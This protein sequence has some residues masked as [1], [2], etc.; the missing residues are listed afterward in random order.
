MTRPPAS[1]ATFGALSAAQQAFVDRLCDA[2]E[3]HCRK[4]SQSAIERFVKQSPAEIRPQVI[5]ELVAI[6]LEYRRR[7]GDIPTW[8]DYE[9]RFP[10]LDPDWFDRELS[11]RTSSSGPATEMT[12]AMQASVANSLSDT[13]GDGKPGSDEA[14]EAA[15]AQVR[16]QRDLGE[17]E[18]LRELGRGGMGRVYLARHRRMDRIVAIKTLAPQLVRQP[19]AVKRFR[20]EVKA[21]ARLVHPNIVTAYDAGEKDGV[22]FLV[23]EYVDGLDLRSLVERDGPLPLKT[24]VD[25]VIQ[26]A[27]GLARAHSRGVVHR[28]VKPSNLLLDTE[29]IVKV[30]DLGL[31]RVEMERSH[32]EGELTAPNML[33]GTV[34]F[35]APEQ[36]HGPMH[37]DARADIYSLGCTLY[38]LLTSTTPYPE[39]NMVDTILAH[40][41]KPVVSLRDAR[42]D[43]PAELDA[44]FRRMLAKDPAERPQ[45]MEDLIVE[46]RDVL[47]PS[48]R[49]VAQQ[50]HES[51]YRQR[52]SSFEPRS[53]PAPRKPRS[54]SAA[55]APWLTVRATIGVVATLAVAAIAVLRLWPTPGGQTIPDHADGLA[56]LG[57]FG[58]PEDSPGEGFA[59]DPA[60]SPAAPKGVWSPAS[61]ETSA[62]VVEGDGPALLVTPFNDEQAHQAQ[63]D[64]AAHRGFDDPWLYNSINMHLMLI[65]PGTFTAG[66]SL[67]ELREWESLA[68]AGARIE[69]PGSSVDPHRETIGYPF[70]LSRYEVRIAEFRQFAEATGY[71]TEAERSGSGW[72]WVDGRWESGADF[73]WKNLGELTVPDDFPACS[74]SWNDAVAF[75]RW[76]SEKETLETVSLVEYR[77]PTEVEWE[78]ACRAGR[79]SPWYF[80]ADLDVLPANVWFVGNSGGIMHPVG[81][82][83]PNAFQLF[84]MLGNEPEWCLDQQADNLR[85]Q[86]GGSYS[87]SPSDVSCATRQL[88]SPST[89]AHGSFRVLREFPSN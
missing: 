48:V 77:L 73:C 89:A 58:S 32:G 47:S 9:R 83:L 23:M 76:L 8:A 69:P 31:A 88:R 42:P 29:G 84:D 28:D 65:P 46:L 59:T 71:V 38:Y 4:S 74:I 67:E 68:A 27:T 6:E 14:G 44:V 78:Y 79:Q 30:L 33:I 17:Y 63:V 49:V 51:V 57:D 40:Q 60:R 11:E 36:G 20:R 21:A 13:L 35:M 82:M 66:I 53:S 3:R 80:G 16:K 81:Q 75:C 70:W 22:H 85:V 15:L 34:A 24:A 45:S 1:Q 41:R 26:T 10:S 86:R 5:C 61:S 12:S 52:S 37:V 55:G 39:K 18:L 7:R 43:V 87:D 56:V 50:R 72:G 25:Y 54:G 19:K 62:P 2:F 64:W